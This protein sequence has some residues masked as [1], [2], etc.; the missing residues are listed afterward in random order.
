MPSAG[1]AEGRGEALV[2][3]I[4]LG[5]FGLGIMVFFHEL[6]H[7]LA[8]KAV[9]IEVEVFSLGWGRRLIGFVR[10]KTVYQIALF[11]VGGFCKLK[12]EDAYRGAVRERQDRFPDVPGSFF[13]ASP[14]KRIIVAISG[15]LSNVLFALVVLTVIWLVGFNVY[16]SDNR[17]VLATDYRLDYQSSDPAPPATVAGL[18]TGDRIVAIDG[19]PTGNFQEVTE[20]VA[21][22]PGRV[23]QLTVQ[24]EGNRLVL[25]VKPELD[26]ETG[27]GR[28]GVYSWTEP[29]VESVEVGSS[30][31]LA[32]IEKGDRIVSVDGNPVAHL[33]DLVSALASK[34][35]RATVGVE[36]GGAPRELDMR[37]LYDTEGNAK[38]G[39]A[40]KQNVY[41]SPRLGVLG[42]AREGAREAYRS[43]RMALTGLATL[44]RGVNLRN[45]VAGPLRISY[46]VGSAA[47]SGFAA[48]FGVGV[49]SFFRFLCLLSVMLFVM[50]LLPL[51]ALDGGQIVVFVV[52]ALRRRPVKPR[53]IHGMQLA[54]F[55]IVASLLVV[56]TFSD[57][58]FFVG[59]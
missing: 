8:A 45:A 14:L 31:H 3:T 42:A 36:R 58:L 46:Y 5:L 26:R 27:G 15:P 16:S 9:G 18:R 43:F 41:R 10:G 19:Q 44:F 24:R 22:S 13:S 12:G 20:R 6:G 28:I 48:G 29:V 2:L 57:I 33:I 37:L 1:D 39:L 32:G 7:F 23:L 25:P 52:E 50:N 51:P 34:P 17:V 47:T 53:V 30:A 55:A 35:E 49:L 40:F 56:F 54:G 21:M 11:P 4:V 59:R 38:L